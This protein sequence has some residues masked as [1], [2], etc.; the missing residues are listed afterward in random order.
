MELNRHIFQL[1]LPI[2]LAAALFEALLVARRRSGSYDWREAGAS[3]GISLGQRAIAIALG[4]AFFG[5]LELAWQWRLYT[6]PMDRPWSLGLLFLAVEFAYYWEHR[7]S[8]EVRW[9]WATHVVHHSPRHLYLA[10]ADR[11]GWTG[12]LSGNLLFFMPLVVLGF[13]PNYVAGALAVNLLYQFW[14][15]TE[16]IGRLGW[17]DRIFNSPSN[18]RVHHATNAGYLDRN[19]GGVLMIFDRLFGTYA[20]ENDR[21]PCRYGLVKQLRSYNPLH[22]ASTEWLALLRDGRSARGL[23]EVMGYLFGPPG[24]QPD[25]RG[26]TTKKLRAALAAGSPEAWPHV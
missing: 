11:L 4:G 5:I 15:H 20:A 6:I 3:I 10:N 12:L 26:L 8:H 17:F 19:Y 21:E 16:L 1:A 18:H 7:S 25:G 22:I 24:W 23:R 9:L 14:L 13:P 2:F